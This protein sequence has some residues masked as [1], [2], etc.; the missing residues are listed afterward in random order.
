M[1]L[2][3]SKALRRKTQALYTLDFRGKIFPAWW[4]MRACFRSEV[5]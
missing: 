1:L 2:L 5:G 3:V 4:Q